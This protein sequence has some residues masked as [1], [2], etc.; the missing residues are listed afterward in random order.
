[1]TSPNEL[2]IIENIA[3]DLHRHGIVPVI[4]YITEG[5][6]DAM[7]RLKMDL[8]ASIQTW[9]DDDIEIINI[10]AEE[11]A[12]EESGVAGLGALFG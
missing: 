12:E 10:L 3:G 6:H 11:E 1:M 2:T 4:V 5:Q 9:L 7:T 8:T